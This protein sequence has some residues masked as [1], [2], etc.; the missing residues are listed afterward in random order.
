MTE[1]RNPRDE[2]SALLPDGNEAWVL[3]PSPPANLDPDWYADD[4]TTLSGATGVVVTPIP[5]EGVTWAEMAQGDDQ[6]ASYAADHWLDGRRRL[7]EL[8]DGYETGRRALH[9]VA[10]FAVAPKRYSATGKLGLRYTHRGFGTPFFQGP[11]GGDEQVRVEGDLIVHQTA[12]VVR[13]EA[14]TT[15]GAAARFL[16]LE[17]RDVWFDDFHDPLEPVGPD[18]VLTVEPLVAD[19]IGAWFGFAT[20]LLELA[21]RTPE[22][23]EVSRVQLWPEHFDPAF[24]MAPSED[25][26]RASY[27]A[28]AGDS[29]HPEPY[30]YIAAWGSID[31]S[32]PF[33]ND[34]TF[35]GASL[36]YRALLD[37][38]DPYATSLAFMHNGY[39]KLTA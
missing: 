10:F 28:S 2:A 29:A 7:T 32:D 4:P 19:A 12:E 37:S 16:E 24:E 22:A 20:H 1:L 35:N 26:S 33:W 21:R 3:E 15:P 31:R 8:P 39:R 13:T 30:F 25:D 18:T 34:T 38:D 17:Y 27:G 14:I 5:G 23:T 36:G 6:I 11:D 9:Q